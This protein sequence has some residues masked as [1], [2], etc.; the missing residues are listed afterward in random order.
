M[1]YSSSKISIF[2]KSLFSILLVLIFAGYS[3]VEAAKR[4]WT[5]QELRALGIYFVG[6]D[7]F[8]GGA[9]SASSAATTT[10]GQNGT[11]GPIDPAKFKT[12]EEKIAQTFIIG[13]TPNQAN[14][15][16]NIVSKYKIG[17]LVLLGTK[18]DKVFN[19][20]YFDELNRLAGTPLIVSTDE[21]GGKI[22]R[23]QN[24][25]VIGN[26]PGA[27]EMGATMSEIQITDLG[28]K[29]GQGLLSLGVNVDLAPVLDIDNG[30]NSIS[31]AG[32]AFSADPKVVAAKAAAFAEGLR[33]A[34]LQVTF[35]HFPGHG[36]ASGK[37]NSDNGLVTTPP[38]SELKTKDLLPYQTLVY[39]T[40]NDAVMMGNLI[41]PG[42]SETN[43]TP[44]SI[45]PAAV[46]LLRENYA[47]GGMITTDDLN[48][49]AIKE[50]GFTVPEAIKKAM[51]AG[52]DAPLFTY[53][54]E[55]DL[56]KAIS[57]V[58]SSV[59]SGKIDAA[60]DSVLNF[61]SNLA[62][63]GSTPAATAPTTGTKQP[64]GGASLATGS[65]VYILGDSITAMSASSYEAVFKTKGLT[66]KVNASSGRSIDGKGIDGPKN[67]GMDAVSTDKTDISAASAIVVALGT[68]GRN[69]PDAI[70]RLM[71]AIRDANGSSPVYW[72]DT[73]AVGRP[74]Y[75]ATKDSN[76][77]IY[78]EA[79][80]KNYQIISW[81]K[82]VDPNIEDPANLS[83]NESDPN[84][85]IMPYAGQSQSQQNASLGVHPTKEGIGALT[86]LVSDRVATGSAGLS[87]NGGGSSGA[88]CCGPGTGGST[89][90]VGKD[91]AQKVFNYFVGKGLTPAQSIGIIG[92]MI[93]ESGIDP[94]RL[95][96]EFSKEKPSSTVDL[97]A[98][99]GLGWGIVQWTPTGKIIKTAHEAG[100]PY[101]R[102]DTLEFQLDFIWNQLNGTKWEGNPQALSSEKGALAA[103]KAANTIEEA[104]IAW[105]QK[106]ERFKGSENLNNASYAARVNSS[107]ATAKTLGVSGGGGGGSSGSFSGASCAGSNGSPTDFVNGFVVYRQNDPQWADNPYGVGKN[108]KGN[109]RTIASSGCGPSALAMAITNLTGK[110]VTPAD[111]AAYGMQAH[112]YGS[113]GGSNATMAPIIANHWGLNAVRIGASVERINQTLKAGG[114]VT[115]SGHGPLPFSEGGHYIVIRALTA[116][117]KWLVGDSSHTTAKPD[118]NTV[119]YDPATLVSEFTGGGITAYAIT[120]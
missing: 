34:R 95:Q 58:K 40:D 22:Q 3:S 94:T 24:T 59:D 75:S 92:N 73:I 74:S 98:T 114:L 19:K 105:G 115:V 119:A 55:A 99:N 91:N 88:T 110:K 61:K 44:T 62:N 96:G 35:K 64:A 42:L 9:G 47:Y 30:I 106:Y 32:R 113:N 109:S 1:K 23:F 112:T 16:K 53:T 77:A 28:L 104:A 67:S 18:D 13:V 15:I 10:S 66:A 71:K 5:E 56:Q 79:A 60:L 118:T 63:T 89:T 20:A 93:R 31:T 108:E 57:G 80:S 76:K 12:A 25:E 85:Y 38:L 117:G 81:A 111:T 29:I 52:V 97:A 4:I 87:N 27:K 17:G 84:K 54:G 90:L 46:K 48:A 107:L 45:S 100:I 103:I 39:G 43:K 11:I 2:I 68:N 26:Q 6:D 21:E 41:V 120:R 70:S 33:G 69:G 101:E 86:K 37:G 78:A 116:E 72:V 8:C 7:N 65:K 50:A 82:T 51:Q 36:R 14:E 102:I 49:G 83:G